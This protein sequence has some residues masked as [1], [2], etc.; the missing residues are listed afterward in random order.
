MRPLALGLAGIAILAI[1]SIA[2]LAVTSPGPDASAANATAPPM[3]ISLEPANPSAGDFLEITSSGHH[4]GQFI[5]PDTL[6]ITQPEPPVLAIVG[7]RVLEVW[8]LKALRPGTG[9]VQTRGSFEKHFTCP[10]PEDSCGAFF[11]SA[12]SP[13]VEVVVHGNAGDADCDASLQSLDALLILQFDASLVDSIPCGDASDMN[14]DCVLDSLDA[15][16]ILKVVA[17]LIPE[18]EF[19]PC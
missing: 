1:V 12:F 15:A 16:L 2:A 7:E 10:T 13:D 18:R 19:Q 5:Y 9:S 8:T 6:T 4:N 17:S 14:E 11:Y 3:D